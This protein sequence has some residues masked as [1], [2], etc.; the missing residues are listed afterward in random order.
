MN[1]I[2]TGKMPLW[3]ITTNEGIN[4][5]V[6]EFKF[7]NFKQALEFANSV[8]NIAKREEHHPTITVS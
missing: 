5:L 6:R 1:E 7:E 8:G 2:D 3:K 4:K